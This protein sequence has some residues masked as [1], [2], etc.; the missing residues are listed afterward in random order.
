M[1]GGGGGGGGEI[2][3]SGSEVVHTIH[4]FVQNGNRKL[5]EICS[6]IFLKDQQLLNQSC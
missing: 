4:K 6:L 3:D 5:A 1:G 2:R